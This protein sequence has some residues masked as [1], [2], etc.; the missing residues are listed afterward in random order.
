[1]P[2]FFS[3]LETHGNLS[4]GKIHEHVR[5]V[6]VAGGRNETTSELVPGSRV[7]SGGYWHVCVS[8]NKED[9]GRVG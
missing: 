5:H 4:A 1:M 6:G 7:K 2:G 9:V 8:N 3:H